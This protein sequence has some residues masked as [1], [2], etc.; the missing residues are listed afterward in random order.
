VA[1][2]DR[3]AAQVW[4]RR[5]RGIEWRRCGSGSGGGAWLACLG[6]MWVALGGSAGEPPKKANVF[7]ESRGISATGCA[8]AAD[9]KPR[10][11]RA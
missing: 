8:K 1:A 6:E 2:R 5:R 7:H 11:A 3:V 10:P 4:V 9:T